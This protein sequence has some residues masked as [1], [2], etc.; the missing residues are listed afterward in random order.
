M[1][2]VSKLAIIFSAIGVAV[3][4]G[5]T[6]AIVYNQGVGAMFQP[7][8]GGEDD[9]SNNF[10]EEPLGFLSHYKAILAVG[11]EGTYDAHSKFGKAPYSFEWK[12]SDGLTLTGENVTRSFELPGKY[13]FYLTVTDGNGDK[14]TSTELYTNVVQEMPKEEVTANTT[15]IQ[16]N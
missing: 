14:A 13:S 4:I 11:E 3:G 10:D 7:L 15:S 5:V 6:I 16:H 1:S 12:F 9:D 8:V 2:R